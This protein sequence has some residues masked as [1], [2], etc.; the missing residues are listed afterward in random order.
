MS[1][2]ERLANQCSLARENYALNIHLT[3]IVGKV[4]SIAEKKGGKVY[5]FY[6][7][8]SVISFLTD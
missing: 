3:K 1:R 6:Y 7:F 8:F 5:T 2:M 4:Y